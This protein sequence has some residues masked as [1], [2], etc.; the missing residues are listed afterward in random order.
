[1]SNADH[2]PNEYERHFLYTNGNEVTRLEFKPM[3][4]FV[5]FGWTNSP[6]AGRELMLPNRPGNYIRK[7]LRPRSSGG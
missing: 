6:C 4:Y 5:D 2:L 7:V 1:M 3:I